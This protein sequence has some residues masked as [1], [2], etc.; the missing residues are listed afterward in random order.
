MP[1]TIECSSLDRFNYGS[2]TV[3]NHAQGRENWFAKEQFQLRQ[4]SAPAGF[5]SSEIFKKIFRG[6]QQKL[7]RP[8]EWR[9]NDS[10]VR[11]F[12]GSS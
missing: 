5:F 12:S 2:R 7:A 10:F 9:C 1:A 8:F 11:F 4:K 3:A 6:Q